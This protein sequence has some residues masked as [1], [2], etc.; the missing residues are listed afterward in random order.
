MLFKLSFFFSSTS[1]ASTNILRLSYDKE[2]ATSSVVKNKYRN[3][4]VSK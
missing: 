3:I 2:E 1:I 4:S